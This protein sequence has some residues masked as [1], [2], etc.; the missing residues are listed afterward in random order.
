V[1]GGAQPPWPTP[2]TSGGIE[3]PEGS[4]ASQTNGMSTFPP[5]TNPP[6]LDPSLSEPPAAGTDGAVAAVL[7]DT[8]P[9]DASATWSVSPLRCAPKK[10]TAESAKT[11]TSKHEQPQR[12]PNSVR[13][14]APS[15]LVSTP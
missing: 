13:M 1:S 8:V 4:N 2:Q 7:A 14:M 3:P 15:V 6:R 9:S 10:A 11:T 12:I 5:L